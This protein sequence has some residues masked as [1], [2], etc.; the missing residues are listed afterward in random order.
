MQYLTKN[1]KKDIARHANDELPNECCGII[2]ESNKDFFSKRC[3][4]DAV[5]KKNNFR[6]NAND[7]LEVSNLGKITA[8]YH[9]HP[10]DKVGIFSDADKK[11]SKAHGL[12]LI[13]YCVKNNKFLEYI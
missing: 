3:V 12:P 6:I 1:I 13:M 10:N 5:N 8:Y 11:V 9:S 4:T 7:Y 2:Y